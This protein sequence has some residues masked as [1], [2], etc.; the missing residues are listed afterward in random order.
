M[1]P[2]QEVSLSAAAAG[3]S[4]IFYLFILFIVWY[5]FNA[6]YNVYNAMLKPLGCPYFI[7]AVQLAVG[8][9]YAIP[10]WILGF[11]KIPSLNFT[12]VFR[13]L[14]IAV[15]NSAGHTASVLAMFRPGGGSFTHVI[16]A[17]EPVV[18]VILGFLLSGAVPKPLTALSLLPITYGVSYAATLGDLNYDRMKSELTS[19]TAVA[20]MIGN[21]CFAL[22]SILRKD[23]ITTDFKKRT[24]MDPQNDMAVTTILSLILLIPFVLIYEVN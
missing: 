15:L 6:G 23:V 17:S 7:A 10:L 11:R 14:P 4:S 5:G 8:L 21:I 22:R 19:Y 9:V 16:K 13:L 12:D 3:S 24:A 2:K 20:A 1:S 18:S